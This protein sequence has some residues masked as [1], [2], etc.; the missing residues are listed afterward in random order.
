MGRPSVR[1][2]VAMAAF[3]KA[4]A[5]TWLARP[6]GPG[7]WPESFVLTLIGTRAKLA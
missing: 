6:Q 2:R 1:H 7:T 5:P 4:G 3:G